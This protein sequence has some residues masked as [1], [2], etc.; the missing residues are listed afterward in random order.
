VAGSDDEG[1]TAGVGLTA[2][3]APLKYRPTGGGDRRRVR[4]RSELGNTVCD[5]K[6]NRKAVKP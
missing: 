1:R 3:L 5:E 6:H 4:A 2:A